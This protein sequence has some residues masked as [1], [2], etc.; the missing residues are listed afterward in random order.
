MQRRKNYDTLLLIVAMGLS[1]NQATDLM[2]IH[3]NSVYQLAQ[4]NPDFR[5]QLNAA[6]A[7]QVD[8][9]QADPV[10]FVHPVT[11]EP[12]L[13]E[14][15]ELIPRKPPRNLHPWVEAQLRNNAHNFLAA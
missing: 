13:T 2:R 6:F 12:I 9:L 1:I 15:F 3:R 11:L 10:H 7:R 5:E 14:D 4:R 8:C